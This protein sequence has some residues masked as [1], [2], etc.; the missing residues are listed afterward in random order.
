MAQPKCFIKCLAINSDIDS[1]VNQDYA[2]EMATREWKMV[3]QKRYQVKYVTQSMKYRE[4]DLKRKLL[5]RIGKYELEEG[6][7]FE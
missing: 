2:E 5:H 3:L 7:I 6:E 4:Q 1:W